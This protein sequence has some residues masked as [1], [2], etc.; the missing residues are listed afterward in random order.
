MIYII[1]RYYIY[2][3]LSKQ[4]VVA[5]MH[6]NRTLE[7]LTSRLMIEESRLSTCDQ[8]V[9]GS[10]FAAKQN[11]RMFHQKGTKR[12]QND[13]TKRGNLSALFARKLDIGKETA[14]R[15]KQRTTRN[16]SMMLL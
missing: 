13:K 8:E 3:L 1:M 9:E 7:K 12:D 6:T 11:Q 15:E 14:P 10:A 5:F 2:L 4:L 16:R